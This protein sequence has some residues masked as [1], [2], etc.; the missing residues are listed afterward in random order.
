[1]KVTATANP[2]RKTGNQLPTEACRRLEMT[3]ENPEEKR[4]LAMLNCVLTDTLC[5]RHT[6]N[7]VRLYKY[8]ET[9]CPEPIKWPE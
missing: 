1:M 9:Q 8:L 5:N 6:G 2:K 7:T 3:A 4:L